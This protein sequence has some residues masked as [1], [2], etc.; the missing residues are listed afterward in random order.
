M[1]LKILSLS[2]DEDFGLLPHPKTGEPVT[3]LSAYQHKVCKAGFYHKY[4]LIVK[5]QKIGLTT[6]VLLEDF[7]R[8]LSEC[9]GYEILLIAQTISHAHEH[10]Y[11]LRYRILNSDKYSQY[12]LRSK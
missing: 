2:D 7:Q 12:L 1:Y 4:R 3:A 6:S 10:L 8:A 11:T 5:S 9:K